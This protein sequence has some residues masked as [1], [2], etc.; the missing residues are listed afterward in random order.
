[1][2]DEV[3]TRYEK[4]LSTKRIR[5]KPPNVSMI[6][7]KDSIIKT[8]FHFPVMIEFFSNIRAVRK[9]IKQNDMM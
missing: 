6:D 9:K 5:K 7:M 3:I 8:L 2:L 4:P 1:M